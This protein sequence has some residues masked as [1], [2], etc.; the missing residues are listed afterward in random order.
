MTHKYASLPHLKFLQ[1]IFQA[2]VVVA[3]P[4]FRIKL[5]YFDLVKKKKTP[6]AGKIK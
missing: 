1:R 4:D 3:I 6:F 2:K 5:R